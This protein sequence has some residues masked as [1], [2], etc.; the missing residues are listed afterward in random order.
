MEKVVDN[1]DV[2]NFIRFLKEK[3]LLMLFSKNIRNAKCID[4]FLGYSVFKETTR[5]TMFIANA[6]SWDYSVEGYRFWSSLNDQW[7]NEYYN[8]VR[9]K[10]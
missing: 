5:P 2:K 6:F 3:N 10:H 1:K 9:N 7:I 4:E 8:G